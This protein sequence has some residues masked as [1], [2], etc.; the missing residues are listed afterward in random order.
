MFDD[1]WKASVLKKR[2]RYCEK[3]AVKWKGGKYYCKRCFEDVIVKGIKKE[4]FHYPPT[5]K[6]GD[7][8]FE[9]KV[10]KKKKKPKEIKIDKY[11]FI[12]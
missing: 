11:K 4:K 10:S 7:D 8:N 1:A 3:A 12:K 9:T 5:R 6:G 2:C